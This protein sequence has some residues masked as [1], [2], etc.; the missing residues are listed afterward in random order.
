LLPKQTLD[1]N[2]AR[3]QSAIAALDLARAQNTQS[4][5]RLDELRINLANMIITSP[6]TGFVSKRLVDPGAYVSQ[7]SPVAEVVDVTSVRLEANIVER[8]LKQLKAGDATRVEVDA[9]PGEHFMGRI[10]R[11]SPVLDPAT[12][13]GADRDRDSQQRVPTEAWHVRTR[14]HSHRHQEGRARRAERRRRRSGRPA[15]RVHAINPVR[16]VPHVA[17]RHREQRA[18]RGG[19]GGLN[20]GDQVITTGAGRVAR[21]AI[22][23]SSPAKAGGAAAGPDAPVVGRQAKAAARP[24]PP[25][26]PAAPRRPPGPGRGGAGRGAGAEASG[27]PGESDT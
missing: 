6:V 24:T 16:G 25:R 10:A 14:R 17:T 9:Y 12:R 26:W 7:N 1:D 11:V 19:A 3:Y 22:A 21:T 13:T 27:R 4:K 23:S 15:R 8:D 2:E 18:H 20:E 5:A